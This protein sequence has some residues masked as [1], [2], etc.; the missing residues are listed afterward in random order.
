[1][2]RMLAVLLFLPAAGAVSGCYITAGDVSHVGG[3][4]VGTAVTLDPDS[5][6]VDPSVTLSTGPIYVR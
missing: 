3:V 6:R 1:M 4:N 2:F 5:G